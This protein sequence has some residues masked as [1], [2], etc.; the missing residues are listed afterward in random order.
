MAHGWFDAV[1]PAINDLLT[2]N[3]V[4]ELLIYLGFNNIRRTFNNRNLHIIAD[5]NK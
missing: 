2:F 4:E 5:K 3:E 1:S